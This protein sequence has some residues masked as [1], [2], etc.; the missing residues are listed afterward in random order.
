MAN[1]DRSWRNPNLLVWHGRPWLIDHGAALY[2]HHAWS[3]GVGSADRFAAQPY[4]ACEHVLARSV[5]EVAGLDAELAATVTD[6]VLAEVVADVPD[7]WL[8]PV[9]GAATPDELRAAYVSF[10]RARRDGVGG[11]RPWLPGA[12]SERRRNDRHPYQYVVLRAVPRVDR[13]EFVNVGVVLYCEESGFLDAAWQVDELRLAALDPGVDSDGRVPG[14]GVRRRRL[15]RRRRA[16]C[17]A[18]KDLGTRFGFL[19]APRSTVVQPGPVHGGLTADP[20][21][22]LERLLDRLVR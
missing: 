1:V 21:G 16:R 17:V 8:A 11:G 6:A 15:P 13:E 10:L 3:G 12:A 19:K 4:D 7:G 14:A 9:P 20:A 18:R 2:F 5:G 22:E